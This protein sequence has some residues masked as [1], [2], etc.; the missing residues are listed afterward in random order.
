MENAGD[1]W[2][3]ELHSNVYGLLLQNGTLKN[4]EQRS[5][6][7]MEKGTTEHDMVMAS[8]TQWT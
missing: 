3:R 2:W 8:P 6:H 5:F 1:G 7:V 4:G